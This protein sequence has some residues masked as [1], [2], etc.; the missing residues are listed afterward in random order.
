MN[1]HEIAA[2]RRAN[3]RKLVRHSALRVAVID[4]LQAGWTPEQIAGRLAL[5][6]AP[7]RVSHE[8]IYQYVY[9]KDGS[10]AEL[11]R[12][13]PDHRRRRRGRG[14]R[15]AQLHRFVDEISIR[16]RP[17]EVNERQTFGAW[18]C[19]LIQFRQDYG[20]TNLTSPVERVSRFKVLMKNS[21]RRSRPVMDGL[22]SSLSPLPAY[23]RQSITFD[24]GLEFLA[25]P[26]LQ[27]GLGV[28]PW[29]CDPRSPWQK[30]TVENT[31]G[32]IRRWLP[33][34]LD[35]KLLTSSAITAICQHLNSTPR[36]C[37]GYRTPAEVF[38]E[39]LMDGTSTLP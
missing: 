23:A 17:A 6:G 9:S 20:G 36:K 27:A 2:R 32:R 38:R 22:I 1:A 18:E 28:A 12:H 19:D 3:L 5:E 11:W 34:E 37:L 33:R 31:N 15:R 7:Q 25:W 8:T 30:G 26:Y 24:R 35:P 39:K 13:L 14:R 29:F 21:D 4:R 16:H 10:A